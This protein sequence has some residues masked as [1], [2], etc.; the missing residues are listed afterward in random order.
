MSTRIP[1]LTNEKLYL[2]NE[3]VLFETYTP[4]FCSF[5]PY[6]YFEDLCDVCS[7]RFTNYYGDMTCDC[8]KIKRARCDLAIVSTTNP[9]VTKPNETNYNV[10]IFTYS[11]KVNYLNEIDFYKVVSK[12]KLCAE[13]T[14]CSGLEKSTNL[15]NIDKIM[16]FSRCDNTT[17]KGVSS[18]ESYFQGFQ[19]IMDKIKKTEIIPNDVECAHVKKK[20]KL[21]KKDLF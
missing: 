16:E 14:V 18:L 2:P 3:K 6:I 17:F 4:L 10:K 5:Y 12:L 13:F 19:T 8:P 9:V 20:K 7:G 1:I 11:Q 15:H 21:T